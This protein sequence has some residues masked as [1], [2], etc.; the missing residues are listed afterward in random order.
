MHGS[1]HHRAKGD[2]HGHG[3]RPPLKMPVEAEAND[4][5]CQSRKVMGSVKG[6]EMGLGRRY[7]DGW[8]E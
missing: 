4:V 5:G 7:R 3:A 1:G 6:K 8:H 2:R